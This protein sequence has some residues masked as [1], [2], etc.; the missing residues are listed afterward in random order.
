MANKTISRVVVS[1]TTYDI[2]DV[3]ARGYW[4]MKNYWAGSSS[5]TATSS[6]L[7]TR[8]W[9]SRNTLKCGWWFNPVTGKYKG[10]S[11]GVYMTDTEDMTNWNALMNGAI[12]IHTFTIRFQVRSAQDNIHILVGIGE[13]L[14]NNDFTTPGSCAGSSLNTQHFKGVTSTN[15]YASNRYIC[16]FGADR[17]GTNKGCWYDGHAYV[18]NYSGTT[19]NSYWYATYATLRWCIIYRGVNTGT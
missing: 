13:D 3:T 5:C 7:N 2:A 10:F 8:T 9:Y 6:N 18:G 17:W 4:H 1:G 19:I 15:F 11:N 16:S 14:D 12:L